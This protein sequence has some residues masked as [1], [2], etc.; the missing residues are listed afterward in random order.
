MRRKIVVSAGRF[1]PI[2]KGHLKEK[3][4]TYRL[5]ASLPVI[6]GELGT[7]LTER[8]LV[9]LA[10]TIGVKSLHWWLSL[11]VKILFDRGE[12]IFLKAKLKQSIY[13]RVVK[14]R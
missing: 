1:K 11:L 3:I 12:K 5:A 13:Q 9:S 4:A 8:Y 2:P 10:Q 7:M 14:F 6:W